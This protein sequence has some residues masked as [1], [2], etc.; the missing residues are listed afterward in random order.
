MQHQFWKAG[1]SAV[2]LA[3][4]GTVAAASDLLPLIRDIDTPSGWQLNGS[5]SKA[6]RSSNCVLTTTRL[7]FDTVTG[8]YF[9][10]GGLRNASPVS[11]SF[12]ADEMSGDDIHDATYET[13]TLRDAVGHVSVYGQPVPDAHQNIRVNDFR[14][15]LSLDHEARDMFLKRLGEAVSVT[16]T[17]EAS[18]PR[19]WTLDL[20]DSAPAVAAFERCMMT[21]RGQGKSSRMPIAGPVN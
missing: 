3:V 9:H 15:G 1:A 10:V 4:S 13:L 21:I 12:S 2:I 19:T 17:V 7:P 14:F 18:P 6:A 8:Y 11:V 5:S 20:E 16:G